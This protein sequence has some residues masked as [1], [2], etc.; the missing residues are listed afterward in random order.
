MDAYVVVPPSDIKLCVDMCITEIADEIRNQG[1]GVLIANG[2]GVDFV[3]VL[4]WSQFAVLFAD[5]EE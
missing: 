2:K 4:Y 5:K 3:I 1:K